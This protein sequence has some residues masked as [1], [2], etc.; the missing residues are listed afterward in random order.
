MLNLVYVSLRTAD[1]A[2]DRV[3]NREAEGGHGVPEEKIRARFRRSHELMPWFLVRAAAGFV[4]DNSSSIWRTFST[5][6]TRT[7]SGELSVEFEAGPANIPFLVART[8][9]GD[10]LS[11]DASAD[12]AP[13]LTAALDAVAAGVAG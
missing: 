13:E 5:S 3:G 7:P 11:R 4:F 1:M 9:F 10:F 8:S 12:V 6:S 2:V